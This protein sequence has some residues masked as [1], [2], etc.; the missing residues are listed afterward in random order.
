[1]AAEPLKVTYGLYAGGF[2]VVDIDGTY[3]LDDGTYT[4][5]MDLETVGVL[6]RLAPWSGL[7][8]SKGVNREGQF[9]PA[10]HSFAG[11]WRG[12]TETKRFDFDANGRLA[13]HTEEKSD[14]RISD[15]M[16]PE[17]VYAG[18]AVDMLTALFRAMNGKSCEANI[19]VMDGKR[20]FDMVFTSKGMD[21]IKQSKYT[22]FNGS[23][24]ICE[25]E[26]IPVAGKWRDKKRG[27]MSIQDQAKNNGQLPRIWFAKVREDM[28]PIPVRFQITT[29]YGSM[30]M[31]LIDI[32]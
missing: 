26:I 3:T 28:P 9:Y 31:H 2:N 10:T 5:D 29:D 13:S 19:P 18:G 22:I 14:G 30:I 11:T 23:A 1:M 6:G 24:E 15:K 21:D 4:M 27:W 25:I 16:P 32:K 20:R 8:R 17:D 7:I 12:D